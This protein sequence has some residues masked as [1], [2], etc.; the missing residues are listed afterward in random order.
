MKK[1]K[2][3]LENKNRD[4]E[5]E[6]KLKSDHFPTFKTQRTHKQT[7]QRQQCGELFPSVKTRAGS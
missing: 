4:D 1:K 2:K 7:I 5:E 3:R 6:E